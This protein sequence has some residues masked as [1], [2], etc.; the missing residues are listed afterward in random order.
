LSFCSRTSFGFHESPVRFLL[1]PVQYSTLYR[2]WRVGDT[3]TTS[4]TVAHPP[5]YGTHYFS[6]PPPFL[7]FH[8]L[9]VPTS[10][11]K[12]KKIDGSLASRTRATTTTSGNKIPNFIPVAVDHHTKQTITV[13]NV[14]VNC[15]T[16][17]VFPNFVFFFT[18]DPSEA[19]STTHQAATVVSGAWRADALSIFRSN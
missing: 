18:C 2:H 6:L 10:P 19:Q 8:P 3:T 5:P 14:S 7:P 15:R 9:T 4:R 17:S 16:L 1:V 11:Q 12:N 13:H